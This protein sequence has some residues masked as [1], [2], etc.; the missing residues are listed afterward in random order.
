MTHYQEQKSCCRM[1]RRYK[2]NLIPKC[3]DSTGGGGA[4]SQFLSLSLSLS[5]SLF[6]SSEEKQLWEVSLLH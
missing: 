5:L 6:L 3:N 4:A 1:Q 2:G